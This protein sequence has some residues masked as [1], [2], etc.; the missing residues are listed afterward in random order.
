MS[1]SLRSQ[2]YRAA[3]DLGNVDAV[4]KGYKRGGVLGAGGGAAKRTVRRKAYAKSNG[5]L[6]RI[7]R[8]IGLG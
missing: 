4:T 3:R 2:M 6:S 5:A 1:K 8:S 7:L